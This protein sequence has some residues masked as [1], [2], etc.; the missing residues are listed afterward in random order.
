MAER[1]IFN[2]VTGER[3]VSIVRGSD[4][5]GDYVEGRG[6]LPV[7][8]RPPGIHRHANQD[9]LVTVVKGRI[10]AIVGQEEREFGPGESAVLPRGQW[11]DFWVV[12]DE[13]AETIARATPALGIEMIL[14]TLAGLAVEGKTDKK[15]RPRPLQG[16]VIGQFYAEVAQFK[17]PPPAVQRVVLPLLA[18]IGRRR[19]YRPYYDRHFEPG[20]V[21]AILTHWAAHRPWDDYRRPTF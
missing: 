20:E 15:G 3:Y 7:G 9:E 12:G 11:H 2:P 8:A 18:S 13:P 6:F 21:E 16:A 1:S 14:A 5:G 4:V 19:G 17:M 10:R